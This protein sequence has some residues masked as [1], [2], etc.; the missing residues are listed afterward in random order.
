MSPN[1]VLHIGSTIAHSLVDIHWLW[2][3]IENMKTFDYVH[4]RHTN[5]TLG[6]F[7]NLQ[8]FHV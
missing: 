3:D 6:I 5:V 1:A 7:V 8:T 4:Q 2:N